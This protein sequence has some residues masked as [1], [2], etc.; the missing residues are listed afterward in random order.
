MI[1]IIIYNAYRR[2]YKR[3]R[4]LLNRDG[5]CVDVFSNY[6]WILVLAVI[7]LNMGVNLTG[8]LSLYLSANLL[9]LTEINKFLSAPK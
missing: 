5:S 2:Q 9:I 4:R 7:I 1:N 8:N 6:Y 3:P